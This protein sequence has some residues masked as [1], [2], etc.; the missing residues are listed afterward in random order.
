MIAVQSYV[1]RDTGHVDVTV[2]NII[3][4]ISPLPLPLTTDIIKTSRR[5]AG[6]EGDAVKSARCEEY[7][8]GPVWASLGQANKHCIMMI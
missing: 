7:M 2:T 4:S 1:L 3:Y 5:S 8:A 6:G